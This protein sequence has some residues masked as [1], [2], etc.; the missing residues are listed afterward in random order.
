MTTPYPARSPS[1]DSRTTALVYEKSFAARGMICGVLVLL[2][3]PFF[4]LLFHETVE[5]T[6]GGLWVRIF[7]DWVAPAMLCI[8]MIGGV[9][10]IL[11]SVLF[12]LLIP[13]RVT[14]EDTAGVEHPTSSAQASVESPGTL[15]GSAHEAADRNH[16]E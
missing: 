8:G 15:V 5:A 2:G 9:L 7:P 4:V 16:M 10:T 12:G 1:S 6:R 3:S 13:S 14:R 11:L